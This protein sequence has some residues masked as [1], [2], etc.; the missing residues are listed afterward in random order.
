MIGASSPVSAVMASDFSAMI[1]SMSAA[2]AGAEVERSSRSAKTMR[3]LLLVMRALADFFEQGAQHVGRDGELLDRELPVLHFAKD[4]LRDPVGGLLRVA[5]GGGHLL[6]IVGERAALCDDDRR[7]VVGELVLGLEP[8]AFGGG[9][10]AELAAD[11]VLPA[12]R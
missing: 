2:V 9:E 8:L 7:V 3:P 1:C 12:P 11:A 5:A 6:E 10:F 4:V